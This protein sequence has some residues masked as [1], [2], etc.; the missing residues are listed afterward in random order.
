MAQLKTK[1]STKGQVILPKAIRD[2]KNWGPG[3]NLVVEE[4]PEGVLLKREPLFPP[5]TPEQVFG[6][7]KYTG[8]AKTIEEM[9]QGVMDEARRQYLKDLN[10]GD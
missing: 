8:P 3:V 4:T 2:R 6:M 7:L 5:T 1:L 9:D 10:A